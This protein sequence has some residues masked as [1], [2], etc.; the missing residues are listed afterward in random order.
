[1]I[2]KETQGEC[3]ME[4]RKSVALMQAGSASASKEAEWARLLCSL[5]SSND[6]PTVLYNSMTEK[7]YWVLIHGESSFSM[8]PHIE[9]KVCFVLRFTSN[10][11]VVVEIISNFLHVQ[12]FVPCFSKSWKEIKCCQFSIAMSSIFVSFFEQSRI[13]CYSLT[14]VPMMPVTQYRG[15]LE[16]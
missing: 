6:G 2:M 13:Y 4:P 10:F 3:I 8:D 16:N 11:F 14:S 1:M 5:C 12:D 7:S 9:R 15:S